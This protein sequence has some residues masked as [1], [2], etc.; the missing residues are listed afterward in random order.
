MARRRDLRSGEIQLHRRPGRRYRQRDLDPHARSAAPASSRTAASTIGKAKTGRTGGCCSRPIIAASI[1]ARTGKPIAS[2]RQERPRRSEGRAGPRSEDD[3]TGAIDDAGARVREPDHPR[4][5]HQRGLW[6]GARRSFARSMCGRASWSGRS[7]RSR[8]PANLGT[9][10]G[11]RMPG[12]QSAARMCGARCRWTRSAASLYC[13]D[14]PAP[15][16]ISTARTARARTC[17]RDC[18]LALDART[19]KRL[20][21]FQMV[22]HDIWDYDNATAPKLLTVRHEGKMVDIVAQAEQAGL[23][24][25]LRSGDG[26]TAVADR[27]APRAE[28]A[29]CRAKRPGRRSRSRRSRRRSRGRNSRRTI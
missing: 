14:R 28:V 8:I 17:S 13:A 5:G 6:L 25:G 7:T 20:W 29:T 22:H 16:T 4:V 1:D 15:N 23:R 24:V 3:D 10:P 2:L 9:R 11:P 12:R 27:G 19:G 18:L 26:R 21:H